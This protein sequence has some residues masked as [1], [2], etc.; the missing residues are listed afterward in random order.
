[1]A[2][3]A[4]E[5]GTMELEGSEIATRAQRG[6]PA[7][8]KTRAGLPGARRSAARRAAREARERQLVLAEIALLLLENPFLDT[9]V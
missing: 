5:E 2:T 7:A 8:G 3:P 9:E 6:T 4:A 1:V